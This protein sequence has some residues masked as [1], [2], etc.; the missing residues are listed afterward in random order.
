MS[1]GV[2]GVFAHAECNKEL[3]ALRSGF[4]FSDVMVDKLMRDVLQI[5]RLMFSNHPRGKF[6]PDK[7]EVFNTFIFRFALSA[8]V[9]AL[10]RI[11]FGGADKVK[12]EKLRND[13]VDM[14]FAAYA[15]FFDGL[16]TEDK[17]LQEIAG[18]VAILLPRLR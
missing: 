8:Y 11:S 7:K 16:L 13:L 18:Y 3:I 14:T 10:R 9:L 2:E 12:A 6:I 5:S 17:R 1:L 15:S 4:R